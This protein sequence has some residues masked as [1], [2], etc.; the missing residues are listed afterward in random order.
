MEDN[1]SADT[2]GA[3][4]RTGGTAKKQ[5]LPA[6]TVNEVAGRNR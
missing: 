5:R 2:K 4:L 3:T 1:F 6:R